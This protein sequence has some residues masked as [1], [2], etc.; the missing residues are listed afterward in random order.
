MLRFLSAR[1]SAALSILDSMRCTLAHPEWLRSQAHNGV[2]TFD[3][4]D[5]DAARVRRPG[6]ALGDPAPAD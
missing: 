5:A 2:T 1:K 6:M 4:S 3:M